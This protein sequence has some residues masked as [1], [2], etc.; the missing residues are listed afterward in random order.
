M[1][2]TPTTH[3]LKTWPEPFTALR[4]GLKHH[5]TRMDDGRGFKV[6]DHLRLREWHPLENCYTG[7]EEWRWVTYI[8]RGPDWG[9]PE[10]MV[11][12]SVAEHRP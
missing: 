5:E 4:E 3:E 7:R 11:V 10:G 6:G 9:I 1:G 12:M 2:D 8:S